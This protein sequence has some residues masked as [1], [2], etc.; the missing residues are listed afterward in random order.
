MLSIAL[1][2]TSFDGYV[3]KNQDSLLR[4]QLVRE[5]NPD[6]MAVETTMKYGNNESIFPRRAHIY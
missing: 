2:N 1:K 5:I 6:I 4:I 3:I